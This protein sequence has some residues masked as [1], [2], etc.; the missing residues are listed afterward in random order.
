VGR[1]HGLRHEV[2]TARRR[3]RTPG[4]AQECRA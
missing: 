1:D 3:H 2:G 4:G